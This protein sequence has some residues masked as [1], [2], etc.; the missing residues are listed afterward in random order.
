MLLQAYSCANIKHTNV[1]QFFN[2]PHAYLSKSTNLRVTHTVRALHDN[3]DTHIYISVA[4]STIYIYVTHTHTHI[5]TYVC[6]SGLY[7]LHVRKAAARCVLH[8]S[9]QYRHTHLY[10]KPN[11]H[12]HAPIHPHIHTYTCTY[13]VDCI[14]LKCASGSAPLNNLRKSVYFVLFTYN[15]NEV[16]C[17]YMY[18][19]VCVY[20]YICR[21]IYQ[22]ALEPPL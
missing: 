9:R 22:R 19:Y 15:D 10:I 12:T 8:T 13:T 1:H 18:V 5:Y 14:V 7:C 21:F 3:T 20:V 4:Q 16:H 11:E 17:I 2:Y 6:H